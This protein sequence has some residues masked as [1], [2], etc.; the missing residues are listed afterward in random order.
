MREALAIKVKEA[1]L[2]LAHSNSLSR[3]A[4]LQKVSMSL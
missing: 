2:E 1:L 4:F 3:H